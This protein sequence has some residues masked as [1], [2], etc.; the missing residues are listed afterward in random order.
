MR[1]VEARDAIAIGAENGAVIVCDHHQYFKRFLRTPIWRKAPCSHGERPASTTRNSA[2]S[3]LPCCSGLSV[4]RHH[5]RRRC[6]TA[7]GSVRL[8]GGNWLA[9][10]AIH[11]AR[12]V[13]GEKK[14]QAR[15]TPGAGLEQLQLTQEAKVFG[16]LS[17]RVVRISCP[18]WIPVPTELSRRRLFLPPSRP[19]GVKSGRE[20]A[21]FAGTGLGLMQ[22]TSTAGNRNECGISSSSVATDIRPPSQIR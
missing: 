8:C 5:R 15:S 19:A 14:R 1:R 12:S 21:T 17:R 6:Q 20:E 4:R 22:R 2:L 9:R 11:Q 16:Q 18:E 7:S 13:D 3:G 10:S